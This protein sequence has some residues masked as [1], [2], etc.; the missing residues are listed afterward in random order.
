MKAS[1]E[2]VVA[3]LPGRRLLVVG[4]LMLDQYIFGRVERISPEAPV[5]VVDVTRDAAVLGGAANVAANLASLGAEVTLLSLVGDDE[6]GEAVRTL[7]RERGI[8]TDA[9]VTTGDRPTTKKTRVIAG[10]Q[11]VVRVDRER[12]GPAPEPVQ[13]ALA[14]ALAAQLEGADAV[15]VSDY[16]KGVIQPALLDKLRQ[17][18]AGMAAPPPVVVDPKDIHFSNYRDFTVV[19]PNL[20]EASLAVGRRL[21]DEA[22][23]RQAGDELRTGHGL[24][25]VLLTRGAD[26]MTLFGAADVEHIHTLA[27][28]VYDVSGAGDT[29]AAV[30]ALGLAAGATASQ[31][32]HLANAAAAVV[33]A[34]VGTAVVEREALIASLEAIE[35]E[36]ESA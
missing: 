34:H 15:L 20:N 18:R 23:V 14:G 5:P 2:R 27:R 28:E 1:L 26:G 6:A 19:T 33:V 13:H 16:G 29:V 17:L 30:M 11:Q 3:T 36:E 10:Q 9:L 21:S 35:G 7:M 25:Y 12:R 24:E 22:A 4:D 32:A 31:A 8:S